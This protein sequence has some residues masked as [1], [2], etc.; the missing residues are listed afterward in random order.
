MRRNLFLLLLLCTAVLLCACGKTQI[1]EPLSGQTV[2]EM[3]KQNNSGQDNPIQD[4]PGQ[5]DPHQPGD[6]L[7]PEQ[8]PPFIEITE[9]I[10][11]DFLSDDPTLAIEQEI[12]LADLQKKALQDKSFAEALYHRLQPYLSS[13]FA[14]KD[15]NALL[16]LYASYQ[17]GE[18]VVEDYHQYLADESGFYAEVAKILQEENNHRDST[19]DL[20]VKP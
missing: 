18:I 20:P 5:D 14:G 10:I 19:V 1:D 8:T 6:N 16:A 15:I 3:I 2:E 12:S 4:N 17:K 7:S 13:E 9:P 11:D